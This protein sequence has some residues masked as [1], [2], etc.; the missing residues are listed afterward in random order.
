MGRT[1]GIP[2]EKRV[3][4]S[5][6]GGEIQTKLGCDPGEKGYVPGENEVRS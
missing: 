3:T 1:G 2:S 4:S 6:R 5:R